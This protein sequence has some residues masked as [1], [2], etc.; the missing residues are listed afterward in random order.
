MAV[1]GI[2]DAVAEYV[3][4]AA[5]AYLKRP[6]YDDLSE[7]AIAI[8]LDSPTRLRFIDRALGMSSA[9]MTNKILTVG[10]YTASANSRG[11]FSRGMKDPS[12]LGDLK[13]EAIVNNTYS[14]CIIRQDMT[15]G[16]VVA[17]L[18]LTN[19]NLANLP[20]DQLAAMGEP[21]DVTTLRER[22]RIPENG[23]SVSMA[24][25]DRYA[26]TDLPAFVVLCTKHY[27]LRD[28]LTNPKYNVTLSSVADTFSQKLTYTFP[29]GS[30]RVLQV[31]FAI[32]EYDDAEASFILYH[33]ADDTELPVPDVPTSVEYGVLVASNT[34]IYQCNAIDPNLEG[35]PE[36]R[37]VFGR[38]HCD[39]LTFL[40]LDL[41]TNGAS[42][43]NPFTVLD[44]NRRYGLNV[45]HPF[46]KQL[47]RIA[48]TWF[49]VM[50]HK[51]AEKAG[52][53]EQLLDSSLAGLLNG[54][55]DAC[56]CLLPSLPV[57]TYKTQA[58][59]TELMTASTTII[60]Q[61]YVSPSVVG[62]QPTGTEDPLVPP[63]VIDN[64]INEV[65]GNV[66]EGKLDPEGKSRGVQT[67][68]YKP[69]TLRII[70]V[71]PFDLD[72]P[73]YTWNV[74]GLDMILAI[75]VN[76]ASIAPYFT[77][78]DQVITPI[79]T[80]FSL[81]SIALAHIIVEAFAFRMV[82]SEVMETGS[83]VSVNLTPE[84]A[85]MR[86]HEQYQAAVAKI[87]M[88]VFASVHNFLV[89]QFPMLETTPIRS[90]L[91]SSNRNRVSLSALHSNNNNNFA[92]LDE[93][94]RAEW[95]LNQVLRKNQTLEVRPD[96]HKW[97]W[98]L[99]VAF[100]TAGFQTNGIARGRLLDNALFLAQIDKATLPDN[101]KLLEVG[102]RDSLFGAYLASTGRI[103]SATLVDDFVGWEEIGGE[104]T[105][106]ALWS[107]AAEPYAARLDIRTL[108][109]LAQPSVLPSN[110][111]QIVVAT[112]LLE[113]LF[114]Q[115]DAS[116]KDRV[117]SR[118][119]PDN[120]PGG[121]KTGMAELT[122]VC[123]PGGLI[124]ISTYVCEGRI[125][126]LHQGMVYYCVRD[127]FARIIKPSGCTFLNAAY[128]FD[129]SYPGNDFVNVIKVP[130]PV[131]SSPA[132]FVL[133]KPVAAEPQ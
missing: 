32:P 49:S 21:L 41:A 15:G 54:M 60:G 5:D 90:N 58:L 56:N 110:E 69:P 46:V 129:M 18:A 112:G 16:I 107:K 99:D 9:H 103:Q 17:D 23:L 55:Q 80:T 87:E 2:E 113:Q 57:M 97:F 53:E 91:T 29:L 26:I 119:N 117:W 116:G 130:H 45:Q 76:N 109:L 78:V 100:K 77:L 1:Q 62:P 68:V 123:K 38:L 124:C 115:G 132:V 28:L 50:L 108:D 48:G 61:A 14:Q 93:K 7:C 85:Y 81:C 10:S 121:D 13:F 63:S 92:T 106:R 4:N 70:F 37:E 42:D 84:Q 75:N 111:Y 43:A 105:W 101:S 52:V 6:D 59:A 11:N 74:N 133:Q 67:I 126:H 82:L 30:E 118:L 122:R 104:E 86:H 44:P 65:T 40:L 83:Q 73:R 88:N 102:A 47:F 39:Y 24:L 127:L 8:V 71:A 114:K 3:T 96:V 31:R 27:A 64:I 34:A 120:Q 25:L 51:L 72:A 89:V 22:L 94:A 35:H 33:I 19:E 20:P 131:R 66:Y 125:S 98:E 12:V 95:P 36:L 128:D 79:V